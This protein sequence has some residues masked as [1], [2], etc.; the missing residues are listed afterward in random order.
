MPNRNSFHSGHPTFLRSQRKTFSFAESFALASVWFSGASLSSVL[1]QGSPPIQARAAIVIRAETGAVLWSKN[2]NLRLPPASL[3][4][5]V[6]ALVQLQ[7]GSL[8][9]PLTVPA[10]AGGLPGISLSLRPGQVYASKDLLEAQLLESANDASA[11]VAGAF[12]GGSPQFVDGMNR[13]AVSLGAENSHFTNPHGLDNPDHYSTAR[14]LAFF[15]REAMTHYPEFARIVRQA[16]GH[17]AANATHPAHLL[18]N[19][20]ELLQ[21]FPDQ[22]DGI[23]TGYTRSAGYCFAGT[24]TRNGHRLITVVLNS[25]D[26]KGETLLL[27]KFGFQ[28]LG[29]VPGLSPKPQHSLEKTNPLWKP[30]GIF[31]DSPPKPARLSTLWLLC[32]LPTLYLLDTRLRNQKRKPLPMNHSPSGPVPASASSLETERQTGNFPPV[33]LAS[34]LSRL[35]TATWIKSFLEEETRFAERAQR[36][37]AKAA[38]SQSPDPLGEA[39]MPLFASPRPL[40]RLAGA[41]LAASFAPGRAEETLLCL[42]DEEELS[43]VLR[44]TAGDRLAEVGKDRHEGLFHSILLRTGEIFAARALLA[45][46][47]LR[48]ETKEDLLRALDGALSGADAGKTEAQREQEAALAVLLAAQGVTAEEKARETLA[49]LLPESRE[50]LLTN[51]KSASVSS[52]VKGLLESLRETPEAEELR[53][54]NPA[55][56]PTPEEIGAALQIASLKLGFGTY[57]EAKLAEI[58]RRAKVGETAPQLLEFP[59]L[60][61]L[62]EAYARPQIQTLI[63]C[64]TSDPEAIAQ[65][66]AAL[67][68]TNSENPI[69]RAELSFWRDKCP[70]FTAG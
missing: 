13:L 45:Q 59:E 40:T 28:Q 54:E 43:S 62:A 60:A 19:R 32:L 17:I 69:L 11:A 41:D 46:L 12:A 9:D 36:A 23:K 15:A 47:W 52:R 44:E 27:L 34:G 38:I 53:E 49:R 58:F 18:T 64:L 31:S 42:L 50:R 30:Q 51:L 24:G 67:A 48:K 39:L 29:S 61:S 4:K 68:K 20:N 7:N 6:T 5:I 14:D 2:P 10:G 16:H 3:T 66:V 70:P 55:D 63:H 21:R 8:S 26:W 57:P 25:P 22:V 56:P 65:S 35:E 1:A 33:V 37:L